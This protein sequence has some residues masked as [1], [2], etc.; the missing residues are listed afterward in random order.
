MNYK[1]YQIYFKVY[2]KKDKKIIKFSDTEIQKHKF[3]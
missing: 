2:I 3:H 1:N